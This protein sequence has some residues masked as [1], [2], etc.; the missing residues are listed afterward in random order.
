METQDVKKQ[1]SFDSLEIDDSVNSI[2]D[3]S[4]LDKSSDNEEIVSFI[5]C[6]KRWLKNWGKYIFFN[7]I[8]IVVITL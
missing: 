5:E 1:F 7:R 4:S 3:N 6:N 8:L 2:N